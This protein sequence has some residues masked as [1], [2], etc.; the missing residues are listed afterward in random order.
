MGTAVPPLAIEYVA[1]EAL[2][3]AVTSVSAISS[4]A[5]TVGET[6]PLGRLRAAVAL[7]AILNLLLAFLRLLGRL[8][9]VLN[10]D[11]LEAGWNRQSADRYGS[12]TRHG[13]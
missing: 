5:G 12:P 11:G 2:S 4:G 7:L 13:R 3:S 10:L 8:A 9:G 1:S 6:L